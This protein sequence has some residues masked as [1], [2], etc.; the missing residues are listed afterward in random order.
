MGEGWISGMT[1][2]KGGVAGVCVCLEGVR[3]DGRGGKIYGDAHVVI[4]VDG[5]ILQLLAHLRQKHLHLALAPAE[6]A[7][8]R[9]Q[10]EAL[11]AVLDVH[12]VP[13]AELL[14]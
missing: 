10:H 12:A 5:R 3:V 11:H 1:D 14:L 6:H 8:K 9:R 13:R 2:L 4:R 7:R